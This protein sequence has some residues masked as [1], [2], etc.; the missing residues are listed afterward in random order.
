[1]QNSVCAQNTS[2]ILVD[3]SQKPF[4]NYKLEE[5]ELNNTSNRFKIGYLIENRF[6]EQA[7]FQICTFLTTRERSQ[8]TSSKIRGFQTP[9]PPSSLQYPLDDVIF[10]HPPFFSQDDFRQKCLFRD[11]I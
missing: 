10:Y 11:K 6:S 8:M 4:S 7:T 1:M 3:F 9:P 5:P 2:K